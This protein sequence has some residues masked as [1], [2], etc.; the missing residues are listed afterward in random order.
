M[1]EFGHGGSNQIIEGNEA[2]HF[3]ILLFFCLFF[4]FKHTSESSFQQ[5]PE[6]LLQIEE[7]QQLFY[8]YQEK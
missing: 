8:L 7:S 1:R 6:G 4:Y 3:L 5:I 2:Y